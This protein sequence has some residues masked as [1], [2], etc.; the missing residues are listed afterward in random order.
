MTNIDAGL[1]EKLQGILAL[2]TSPHEGEA[3]NAAAMLAKLLTKHNLTMAD[4][5]E[6]GGDVSPVTE[7]RVDIGKAN[8]R[9][10]GT[11]A[12]ILGEAYYC[13]PIIL[14]PSWRGASQHVVFIGRADNVEAASMMF[15]W[16]IE[17]IK[18]LSTEERKRYEL[19]QG[20][21]H[22]PRWAHNFGMGA[23]ARLAQ[24][25]K[26]LRNE[27]TKATM[28]L[29]VRREEENNEYVA[30]VFGKLKTPAKHETKYDTE[31]MEARLAGVNSAE[32]IPLRPALEG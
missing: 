21:T 25:L 5:E 19:Y 29:V 4:I 15:R 16:L 18:R 23:V 6:R 2:T 8:F 22:A 17:N 30:N 12:A 13:K 26:E 3:A 10:V 1:I 24:R 28:A 20:P 31:S 27:E 9:W 11:L 14:R 32:R 7:A